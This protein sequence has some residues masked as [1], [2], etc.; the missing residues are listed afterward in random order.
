MKKGDII[1][2]KKNYTY[3]GITPNIKFKFGESYVIQDM[4]YHDLLIRINDVLFE[5]IKA[6]KQGR[7]FEDYFEN[8]NEHRARKLRLLNINK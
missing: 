8:Y 5:K 7:N 1:Y 6:S 2:C 3:T 4:L